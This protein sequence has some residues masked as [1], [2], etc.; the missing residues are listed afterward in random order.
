MSEPVEQ[1]ATRS[2]AAAV[3]RNEATGVERELLDLHVVILNNYLRRHHVEVYKELAKRVGKLTILISTPMEPDR[4]WKA[5]WDGLD[6]QVQKNRMMTTWW[7]HSS[8]FAEQNFI[9]VPTDTVKRLRQLRPDV[10]LSYEMGIRTL[11]SSVYRRFFR[12]VPLV[13]VGN[14]SEHIERERGFFRRFVRKVICRGVDYFTYN[15]PSCKR[16]LKS[17]KI[18][19]D[20][21][22]HFPYCINQATVFSGDKRPE[23]VSADFPPTPAG[24]RK[25]LYCGAISERKGILQFAKTLKQW[26]DENPNFP[27]ELAIAGAGPLQDDVASCKSEQLKINFLGN[28]DTE[29]LQEAYGW[30]EIAVFPTLADEWGLVPIEAMASGL[31]VLGSIHAQSVESYCR[32]GV[33]G[34]DFDP[35]DSSTL[36]RALNDSLKHTDQDLR[37]MGSVARDSV[38]H[39]SA[40][41]SAQNVESMLKTIAPQ[42]VVA[43]GK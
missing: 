30:A 28:C 34:W 37:L 33:N 35:G 38:A 22:F 6:V 15:G 12:K 32:D 29:Q 17:L 36:T 19:E 25:L 26:S 11:L 20:K 40:A 41:S 31:P 4:A 3:G 2:A 18:K 5:Q 9:H 7:R 10:I 21:L 43:K 16:Y 23:S 13:M 24:T 39:I 1:G 27:I 8:G 42:N 14:M